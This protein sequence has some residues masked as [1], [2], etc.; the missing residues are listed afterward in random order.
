ME[1]RLSDTPFKGRAEGQCKGRVAVSI[2]YICVITSCPHNE[3]GALAIALCVGF[4]KK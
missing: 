3:E 4:K 2:T 1:L